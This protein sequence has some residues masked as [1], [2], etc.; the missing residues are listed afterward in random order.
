MPIAARVSGNSCKCTRGHRYINPF[1]P[2]TKSLTRLFNSS[3]A[4]YSRVLAVVAMIS[5]RAEC[6]I[7]GRSFVREVRELLT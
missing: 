3:G 4:V 5:E 2:F 1:P 6:R 7:R